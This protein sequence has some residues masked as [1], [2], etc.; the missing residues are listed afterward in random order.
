[1]VPQNVHLFTGTILEN[2]LISNE[3]ANEYEINE[4]LK[5]SQLYEYVQSLPE[6]LNT[7]IGELGKKLSG[8]E[9]KR[10]GIARAILR[11][12]PII[13]FDEVT[14]HLDSVTE[15]NI[16]SMIEQI[17]K[18]KSILFITHRLN[19]MEMFDEI[20]VMSNGRIIERGNHKDLIK[21]NGYYKK[22][23]LS[24]NKKMD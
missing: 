8:G 17:S 14:S 3:N 20:L 23:L 6:K 10:L 19:Q 18:D 9:V 16:L 5:K 24:Q 15:K 1:V 2:L 12:T 7:H 13:I 22:L 4:A 21:Q 11:N